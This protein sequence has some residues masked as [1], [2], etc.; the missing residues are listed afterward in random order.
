[1]EFVFGTAFL[2]KMTRTLSR[3]TQKVHYIS[4]A[5]KTVQKTFSARTDVQKLYMTSEAHI[6]GHKDVMAQALCG[7][8]SIQ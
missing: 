1:M 7:T 5:S 2:F 8:V 3:A 4:A 6:I